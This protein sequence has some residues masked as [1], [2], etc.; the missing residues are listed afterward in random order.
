MELVNVLF[1]ILAIF[2]AYF[3]FLYFTQKKDAPATQGHMEMP[4]MMAPPM[5][6]TP[7]PPQFQQPIE[8]EPE[9]EG[10][11][12]LQYMREEETPMDPYA[13]ENEMAE[14]PERLRHPERMF[15]AAPENNGMPVNSGLMGAPHAGVAGYAS[16]MVQNEGEF[17]PGIFA[18]DNASDA[19]NFSMF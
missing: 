10:E 13:E 9:H 15:K 7:A 11:P 18:F 19:N 1:I 17:M 4:A 5:K 2:I 8:R 14:M 16:E 6:A 3:A 12:A